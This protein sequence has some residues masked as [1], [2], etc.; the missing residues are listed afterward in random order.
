MY[1]HITSGNEVLLSNISVQQSAEEFFNSLPDCMSSS[2]E[3]ENNLN[4]M[5]YIYNMPPDDSTVYLGMSPEKFETESSAFAENRSKGLRGFYEITAGFLLFLLGFV[6]LLCAAGKRPD[7]EEIHLMAIDRLYMD[8]GFL[9]FIPSIWVCVSMLY[10][11]IFDTSP[12]IRTKSFSF[13]KVFIIAAG[14][15]IGFGYSTMIA[16]RLKRRELIKH[17]LIYTVIERICKLVKR[18]VGAGPV[19]RRIT[20]IFIIYATAVTASIMLTLV[21]TG[22]ARITGFIFGFIV[23][24]CVNLAALMFLLKKVTHLNG[25]FAGV[26]LIKQGNLS[27]RISET[28]DVEISALARNINNIADGLKNAMENEVKSERMKTELVTNV[29]HDLKTPLTSIITYVDLL[30]TEG[31]DSDN[32]AKYLEILDSKSQHLKTLTEDLFEVS[33]AISGSLP[34]KYEKIEI[35]SLIGRVVR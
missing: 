5:S 19:T 4:E 21:L 28:G 34:V 31:L 17:T 3:G 25:I 20:L 13:V 18:A 35:G 8:I 33:K 10:S 23:F 29:S 24:L 27:Y 11:L 14:V 22:T 12:P 6:Y 30:K 32:A 2:I 1:Y 26:E 7:S 16:K 15:L 9:L